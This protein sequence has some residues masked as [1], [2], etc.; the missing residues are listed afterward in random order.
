MS[1]AYCMRI[2]CVCGGWL[3][4]VRI[5]NG[6]SS[7]IS[8]LLFLPTD[9]IKIHFPLDIP[10]SHD[11]IRHA[12]RKFWFVAGWDS[13]FFLILC[14]NDEPVKIDFRAGTGYGMVYLEKAVG[15]VNPEHGGI[16]QQN[17]KREPARVTETKAAPGVN[18]GGLP[19]FKIV[20]K[21]CEELLLF[22]LRELFVLFQNPRYQSCIIT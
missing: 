19:G 15:T 8:F 21:L 22:C 17:L 1:Y 9:F 16:R 14:A 10:I 7:G 18:D 12:D 11:G 5:K 3:W 4:K 2:I 13:V 6:E 20:T